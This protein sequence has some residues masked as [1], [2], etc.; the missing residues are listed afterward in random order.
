[1]FDFHLAKRYHL[2]RQILFLW[3]FVNGKTNGKHTCEQDKIANLMNA[4]TK[5][6]LS[7]SMLDL[8]VCVLKINVCDSRRGTVWTRYACNNKR[9]WVPTDVTRSHKLNKNQ[10]LFSRS[11]SLVSYFISLFVFN[12]IFFSCLI[13][14]FYHRSS[15][16]APQNS[17]K[18]QLVSFL[19]HL[20][21][22]PLVCGCVFMIWLVAF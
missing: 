11:L 16:F 14:R 18:I 12:I 8:C 6:V 22:P 10:I 19:L 17:A 2:L 4:V 15:I 13:C 20:H 5:R 7:L 1:M 9:I 21:C 3:L